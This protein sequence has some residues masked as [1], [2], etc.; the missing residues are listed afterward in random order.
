MEK[1]SAIPAFPPAW[2]DHAGQRYRVVDLPQLLGDDLPRLPV[3]LRLLLENVVRHTG[4]DERD[5]GM[6]AIV[7]WLAHGTSAAEIAF[8]PGRVLMHDTTSTPALVDIAAMRDALAEAGLDPTVLN[9]GL[10]VD[11]SVDHSLA[12]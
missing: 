5:A 4:G 11:V 10:P 8:Q 3:V 1:S 9:P 7:D 6:A 12:V 2:L